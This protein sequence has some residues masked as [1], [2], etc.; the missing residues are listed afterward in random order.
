V[1]AAEPIRRAS[2]QPVSGGVQAHTTL[3]GRDHELSDLRSRIESIEDEGSSIVV[4]GA[5]GMGKSTLLAACAEIADRADVLVLRTS[6][7][8]SES[9]LPFAGLRQLLTPLLTDTPSVPDVQH[10][11]LLTAFGLLEGPAP[12]LFLVALAT[13]NLIADT[14]VARPVVLIVDD[15]QWMDPASNDVLAFIS[16]RIQYDPIVLVAGIR[17]GHDAALASTGAREIFLRG[18]DEASAIE[19]L[20]SSDDELTPDARTAILSY[21]RGNPL[22]L[23]ELPRA[24]RSAGAEVL[25]A[26]STKVPLT[27]R[28]ERAFAARIMDLPQNTRDALLIA[29]VDDD[30]NLEEILAGAS[31]L[32]G[33]ETTLAVLES[34]QDADLVSFDGLAVRFRHP[35]VRSGVLHNESLHRQQSAHAAMSE[36]LDAQPFRKVWHQAQSVHGPDDEIADRLDASHMQS[37]ARGSI[38]TAVAALER[39]AELTSDSTL[40]GRRLLLAAQHAFALGHVDVVKRL[41]DSAQRNKLSE[42]DRARAEWLRQIFTEG[43]LGT[44]GPIIQLCDFAARCVAVGEND[45]A[46]DLLASAALRSWWAVPERTVRSR[47]IEIAESMTDFQDD[48]RLIAAIALTE[49]QAKGRQTQDRLNRI[50]SAEVTDAEQ[51]VQL[52][53]AARA[54]GAEVRATDFYDRAES[55]VREHGQLGLL[56]RILAVHAAVCIDL[57]DWRRTAQSLDEAQ[58]VAIE[59]GQPTWG[60]GIEAVEVVFLGH[61]GKTAEA[62]QRAAA[63]ESAMSDRVANDFLSLAQFARG[64]AYLSAGEPSAAYA[65]LVP[66]FDASDRRHHPRETLSALMLLVEAAVQSGHAEAIKPIVERMELL[67][68]ETQSPILQVHL[69]YSRPLLAKPSAAE[70]LF[71]LGLT[72]DLTRWPWPRARLELEFG[73][74]LR[75]Q[76]RPIESREPLRSALAT[77][78]LIGAAGW[79]RTARSALR[80]AGEL[81]TAHNTEAS[82]SL[83]NAQEMQIA[84]LAA[85]GLSNREIGQRLFLSPRTVGSHLYRIYPKLG[86]KSRAQLSARLPE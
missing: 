16:R 5:A 15:V 76:R 73:N 80:A 71:R 12:Q 28:L 33:T 83:M 25:D 63:L 18:L 31:I 85:E 41:V 43:E 19:L 77:F 65:Q 48:A 32:S 50:P 29:A 24:W 38:A 30:E 49:P 68:E 64:A 86:I 52:G 47:L 35:L 20:D 75:R 26:M 54:A 66:M 10:R 39:S 2:Q 40:R 79:A 51:L 22:A 21:A 44:S 56:P 23:V 8:E 58:R 34:A 69:L 70:A 4:R 9:M 72:E 46:L 1:K 67:A 6:G 14:A 55:K 60:T 36:T 42:P 81:D 57:G 53:N 74:W 17:D 59:T 82:E 11:A 45:L 37:L 61:L 78:D 7:I 3:I 62:L 13:L 84:R 27:T